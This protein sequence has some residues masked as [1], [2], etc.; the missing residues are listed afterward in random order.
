MLLTKFSIPPKWCKFL[1]LPTILLASN[2]VQSDDIASAINAVPEEYKI[3]F[4]PNNSTKKVTI[5]AGHGG[6]EQKLVSF[7]KELLRANISI[8]LIPFET[9]ERK[10]VFHVWCEP[11]SP[12]TAFFR[13]YE[14]YIDM[15]EQLPAATMRECEKS[16]AARNALLPLLSPYYQGH[17]GPLVVNP[18]GNSSPLQDLDVSGFLQSV[19]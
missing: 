2:S 12:Q 7:M 14:F 13:V 8:D 3:S 18:D 16:D 6:A 15:D 4:V 11:V 19:R 9:D 10:F 17:G 1:F 5:L